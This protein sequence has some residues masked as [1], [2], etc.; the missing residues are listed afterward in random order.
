MMERA[1][2]HIEL[3][4][5]GALII[6]ALVLDLNGTVTTDGV[7]IPGVAERVRALL[8]FMD[9]FLVTADTLGTA[10]AVAQE[11]GCELHV[12]ERGREAEQKRDWVRQLGAGH[13]AAIGN[14][15]N[16]ALMLKEVALGIAVIGREGAAVPALLAA[17][18]VVP[19]IRDA[20]DLFL[21]PARLTAT[22]RR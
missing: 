13:A 3:P 20:L 14:G 16:D 8:P 21:R 15:A 1:G 17:D 9:V 12:L 22:L 19:D 11:L 2:V 7:L 5:Q 10:G 4:G 18:V 6:R